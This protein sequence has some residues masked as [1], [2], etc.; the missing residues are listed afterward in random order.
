[1]M[2]QRVGIALLLLSISLMLPLAASPAYACSCA[3]DDPAW[4]VDFADVVLVG[5]I[6]NLN[7]RG[8]FGRIFSAAPVTTTVQVERYLKGAG[9]SQR[10][11]VSPQDS[12]S[13]GFLTP[14]D[15][16][17]RYVLFLKAPSGDFNATKE[18]SSSLC[19]GNVALDQPGGVEQLAK[20]EAITGFGIS[21]KPSVASSVQDGGALWPWIAGGGAAMTLVAVVG[22]WY[23]FSLRPHRPP[24]GP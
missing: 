14:E 12:A 7:Y 21:P 22:A 2:L 11:F 15:A 9:E 8:P 17:K 3:S 10:A 24:P 6:E 19:S 18:Y 5:Q 16:G 4:H 23:F 1:M 13:C 20:V